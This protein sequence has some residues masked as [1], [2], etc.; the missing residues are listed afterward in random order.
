MRREPREADAGGRREEVVAAARATLERG[1]NRGT[2]GNVSARGPSGGMLIT[3]SAAPYRRLEPGDVVALALDG[4]A[5][6]DEGTPST[7]WRLHAAVY[8]ERPE[9]GAVVHAHPPFSTALACARRE[10]PA[11]HYRV[12]AAGGDSIRCAPYA[13]FGSR[14]LAEGALQALEGRRACLLAN[15]GMVA[16]GGSP[17]AALDL[18]TTVEGLAEAY[19]R[20]LQVGEP[21]LLSGEQMAEV[22]DRMS[23]YGED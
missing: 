5:R 10:I 20:A 1:L 21:E 4:T 14:E 12:A 22:R 3:P 8:R 18:A 19:W 7:E 17:A 2:A 9:A 15:H 11:F 23:G 6:G 16:L 13:P